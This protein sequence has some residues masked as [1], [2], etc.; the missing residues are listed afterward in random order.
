MLLNQRPE[1]IQ[2]DPVEPDLPEIPGFMMYIS[3]ENCRRLTS[4]LEPCPQLEHN[5]A[6]QTVHNPLKNGLPE[7]Y[8]PPGKALAEARRICQKCKAFK[9]SC[10]R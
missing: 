8:K 4:I 9:P 7:N 6:L 2:A 10:R 5:Q 3:Y 1:I